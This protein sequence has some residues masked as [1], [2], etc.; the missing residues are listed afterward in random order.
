MIIIG[1]KINATIPSTREII[2]ERDTGKLVELAKRQ[3]DAGANYID[4]NVGLDTASRDEE[5]ELMKWAVEAVRENVDKP[6]CIDSGD[7]EVLEVGLGLAGENAMVNSA[8]AEDDNLAEVVPLAAKY[9]AALVALAMDET[10]IP[11]DVEGRLNACG[12]IAAACE[13]HGVPV[14]DV[15]FDP[16]VLPVG[17]DIKQGV[18]TL[19]TIE[20]IKEKYPEAKTTM[21]LS[22]ISFGLPER[23]MLNVA[24]LHMAVY[25]GLDSAIMDP[26]NEKMVAAGK[27]AEALVGKDRHCRKYTRA[28][29]KRNKK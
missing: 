12:K 4:V 20:G 23:G 2:A 7:P 13:K 17:A 8:K 26:T 9:S 6:L 27:T 5:K 21:G 10:G 1:E 16:L 11:K 25:A 14:K 24:F 18:V 19:R 15:F 3:S 28:F 29:R 22:N